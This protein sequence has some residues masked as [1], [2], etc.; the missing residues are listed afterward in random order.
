MRFLI[1]PSS[2]R[3][4]ETAIY[5]STCNKTDS[6]LRS[7][8]ADEFCRL[9]AGGNGS[10]CHSGG[11]SSSLGIITPHIDCSGLYYKHITFINDTSTV[12]C[13]RCHNL[14]CHSRVIMTPIGVIYIQ[15]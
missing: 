6:Y 10:D 1:N 13:E 8:Y 2:N 3:Y 7:V 4:R 14:E 11:C 5:Y 12:A 15:L 9:V